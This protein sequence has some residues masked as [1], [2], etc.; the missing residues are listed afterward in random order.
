MRYA[1][2]LPQVR[3]QQRPLTAAAYNQYDAVLQ[4]AAVD[5]PAPYAPLFAAAAARR[6]A[7]ARK[8]AQT[9]A[10]TITLSDGS[11][12]CRQMPLPADTFARRET[13]RKVLLPLLQNQP[14]T[15]AVDVRTRALAADI[16][17]T[18]LAAAARL[19]AASGGGKPPSILIAGVSAAAAAEEAV[20][21][22]ANTLVRALAQLPPNQLTPP[23]FVALS[24]ALARRHNLQVKVY[25]Y[26]QLKK[27][28]AGAICAV[29]RA[30]EHL[31][32]VVHIA[33]NPRVRRR[34]ALVGKGVC[35]DTGGVNVKPA[36]YMRGMSKDM[37][38]AAVALASL[39]AAAQRRL[40]L[41]IDCWLALAEN[42]IAANAYR[43]DEVITAANGKRIEV[44]HSDAEGRMILADTL[45]LA[46][47]RKPALLITYA[48][49][50]GTM[51][52]A[53]GERMSG[54]FASADDSRRQAL[55]A[56]AA[57]GERLCYFPMPEDYKDGLK[58]E[59]ADIKQ[60]REDGDADHIYA[61]LF[62]REFI[63]GNPEW[64]HVDLS[65]AAC[66]GGLAAAPTE[67]SGF[68]AAWTLALLAERCR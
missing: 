57:S 66:K 50:T 27:L 22:Q 26:A 58:S 53:L 25:T 48:T 55:A 54:F 30:A 36:R 14:R 28:G 59:V 9:G 35:Y 1:N 49:L 6:R 13:L 39:L 68:G 45:A 7:A 41:G 23:Q 10:V 20:A 51:H 47:R 5:K 44:V 65:A 21:A 19:P 61:A 12:V 52:T 24:R 43:P 38:G 56:A 17:Y 2:L 37:T 11:S 64:L 62:L 46:S 18:V 3:Y 8:T 16:V 34:V 67:V 15:L 31:P 63:S 33:Y 40:P 4:L 29:G 60:C 42:S 32:R